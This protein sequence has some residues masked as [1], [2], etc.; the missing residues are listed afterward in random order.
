MT[1]P[2]YWIDGPPERRTSQKIP[3]KLTSLRHKLHQKA[4]Q[5]PKFRFYTLYSHLYRQ[6]VLETAWAQVR[7]NKG[8]PGVDG[9]T[10]DQIV[11]SEDGSAQL[12]ECCLSL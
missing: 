8:A 5:E 3:E 12:I 1:M 11:N 2:W 4:K 9:V 6:D 7:R 10:I